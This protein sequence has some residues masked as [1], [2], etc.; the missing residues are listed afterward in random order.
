M[1]IITQLQYESVHCLRSCSPRLNEIARCIPSSGELSHISERECCQ[2]VV[3]CR[4]AIGFTTC[5]LFIVG[6]FIHGALNG[7]LFAR[8]GTTACSQSVSRLNGRR[9]FQCVSQTPDS[10][11]VRCLFT[12]N[13]AKAS[14][15]R[16]HGLPI[17]RLWS[18]HCPFKIRLLF[19][20]STQPA[21]HE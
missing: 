6:T 14:I 1:I 9:S 5:L 11:Y 17:V 2:H 18:A 16:S 10:P 19:I 7:S 15:G 8:C 12:L 4:L 21:R 20:L 3:G 13:A